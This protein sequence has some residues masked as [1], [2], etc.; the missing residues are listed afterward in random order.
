MENSRVRASGL[1][2]AQ[3]RA[4]RQRGCLSLCLPGPRAP[5]PREPKDSVFVKKGQIIAKCGSD[6]PV[7][8]LKGGFS[9]GPYQF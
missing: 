5:V 9:H 2:S 6:A 4:A 1:G 7:S 3:K 8:D